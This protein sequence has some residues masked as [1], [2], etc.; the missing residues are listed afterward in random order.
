MPLDVPVFQNFSYL[1]RF[2]KIKHHLSASYGLWFVE[3]S[4]EGVQTPMGNSGRIP[5][6]DIGHLAKLGC[7]KWPMTPL[8]P[9]HKPHMAGASSDFRRPQCEIEQRRPRFCSLH[10]YRRYSAMLKRWMTFGNKGYGKA[11]DQ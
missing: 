4:M 2:T 9:S 8:T 3:F 10:H 11:F 1:G 5:Y 6:N 7:D